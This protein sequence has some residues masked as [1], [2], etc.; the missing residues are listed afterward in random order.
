[1]TVTAT[2][3][4]VDGTNLSPSSKAVLTLLASAGPLTPTEIVQSVGFAS[5]TVRYALKDLLARDLVDKK[6]YL[7]DMRRTI[8]RVKISDL[9]ALKASIRAQQQL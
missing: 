9:E 6:P 1:M 7:P 8:Y 3:Q 5:R 4:V 2:S